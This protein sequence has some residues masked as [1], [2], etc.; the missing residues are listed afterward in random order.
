MWSWN[1]KAAGLQNSGSHHDEGY[2]MEMMEE[3][4]KLV[5]KNIGSV[6]DEEAKVE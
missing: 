4:M 2:L 3:K 1:R 6:K 5:R